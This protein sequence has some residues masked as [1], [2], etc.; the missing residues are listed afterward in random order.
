[1]KLLYALDLHEEHVEDT[2]REAAAWA[3]QL[4]AT[5][6]LLFVDAFEQSAHLIRDP[7]VREVVMGQWAG[8]QK[9]HRA[10]L[11][12]LL[13]R[14]DVEHRGVAHYRDGHPQSVIRDAAADVDLLLV[15]THGRKGLA[16]VFLG[17]VAEWLVRH[18][19]KPILVLR[20][21]SGA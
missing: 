14:V 11:E 3:R 1:M 12:R 21:A 17:S 5:L 16:H 2:V 6:D 7:D 19:G 18:V 9:A 15:A 10:E 4:G 8:V 20:S 13:E